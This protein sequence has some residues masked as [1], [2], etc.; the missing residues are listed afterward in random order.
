V[1]PASGTPG[2][3]ITLAGMA[4]LHNNGKLFRYRLHGVD[5][6]WIESA[7][8]T[9]RYP[10]LRPG[11]YRFQ[12]Y[13][14]NDSGVNSAAPVELAFTVQPPWWQTPWAV[15][16]ACLLLGFLVVC[17][18]SIRLR[19]VLARQRLL[20]GAVRSRTAT[21][22]KQKAEIEQLLIEARQASQ[23]KSAF[24]ANMSHEIRT[25]L[26]GVVGMADLLILADTLQ[27][28]QQAQA[29]TLRKSALDLL[30]LLNDL[31]DMAKIEAGKLTLELAPFALDDCLHSVA[32]LMSGLAAEKGLTLVVDA[33]PTHPALLG[34]SHRL[35]QVLTNLISNA[36]KFSTHGAVTLRVRSVSCRPNHA[37]VEF[38]VEDQGIGIPADR[39]EAVFGAFEQA[40][41]S[42]SR[43]FGGS[44]LGLA[45][46]Q[47]LVGK[48]GGSIQVES[49]VG[50]GSRFFFTLELEQLPALPAAANAPTPAATLPTALRILL[51]EDNKVN[52]RVATRML[53]TLGHQV[54]IAGDG[55]AAVDLFRQSSFDVVLMD[56]MMPEVDGV[57]ATRR[58][59]ELEEPGA[60][61]VP[62]VA[63][64]ASA[65]RED[66]DRCRTAGMDGFVSKP[67]VRQSLVDEVA[68]VLTTPKP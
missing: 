1:A 60:P 11:H 40:E 59:R 64:T 62:I 46:C 67:F 19:M 58:I 9:V 14:I 31:L 56:L 5:D 38:A 37:C 18:W 36:I 6:H 2:L 63:L 10:A 45:I 22:E 8:S 3:Q 33:G 41:S 53:E 50:K 23:A 66:I 61:R 25:P 26:N 51:C 27:S 39:L 4:Y 44:G 42:T 57:E 52:Q 13:G 54:T 47:Q 30:H 55:R 12:A 34:D 17:V 28:E 32:N 24:L 21:V 68:R 7:Q 43:R 20:E 65:F 29:L 16:A 35:R 49:A 15:F 48:M